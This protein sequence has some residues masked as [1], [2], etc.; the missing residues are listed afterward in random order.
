MRHANI[1]SPQ[2]PA[3]TTHAPLTLATA[4]RYPPRGS[5]SAFIEDQPG[6]HRHRQRKRSAT[7]RPNHKAHGV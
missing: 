2:I 5:V 7:L 1:V 4:T 3:A 6:C